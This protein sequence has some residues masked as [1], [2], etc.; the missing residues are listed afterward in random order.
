VEGAALGEDLPV[1]DGAEREETAVFQMARRLPSS[2]MW[3]IEGEIISVMVVGRR[4][5]GCGTA[6]WF[7]PTSSSPGRC[8]R[9]GG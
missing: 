7:C 8:C 2:K 9:S 4:S 1:E 6:G 5:R 3:I